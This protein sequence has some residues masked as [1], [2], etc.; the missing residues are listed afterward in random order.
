ME[1]VADTPTNETNIQI[2]VIGLSPENAKKIAQQ[3]ISWMDNSG[4]QMFWDCCSIRGESGEHTVFD[5]NY[6]PDK[7]QYTQWIVIK[8]LGEYE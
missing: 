2:T 4:E 1:D 8:E 6:E 3:F 5:Y 7:N